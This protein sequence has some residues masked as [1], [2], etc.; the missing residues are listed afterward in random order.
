MA[1]MI[2]T[3]CYFTKQQI[4][5]DVRDIDFMVEKEI[6]QVLAD[7]LAHFMNERKITQM[8]LAKKVGMGQTT[9]SLYLHPERRKI[10]STGK[11]PSAKLSDVAAI[12]AC[13][14]I[15]I[16]QLLRP[17]TP[18]QRK[19]YEA[20]EQAFAALNPEIRKPQRPLLASRNDGPLAN[21]TNN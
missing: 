21:G 3:N 19:A 13:L 20:I 12:A 8:D 9:V 5:T 1:S 17:L 10:S 6:N 7:N 16:W 11:V 14:D 4:A 18:A 2:A 15:E